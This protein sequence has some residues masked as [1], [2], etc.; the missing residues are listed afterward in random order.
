MGG[1]STDKDISTFYT[2]IGHSFHKGIP[3]SLKRVIA[4]FI[5]L[6]SRQVATVGLSFVI[7]LYTQWFCLTNV[8][9][10]YM[11]WEYDI[12]WAMM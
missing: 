6:I 10:D 7:V 9:V 4:A 5:M 12:F 11:G 2:W 1:Q 3:Y 8:I